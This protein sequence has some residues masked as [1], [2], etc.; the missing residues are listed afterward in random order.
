MKKQKYIKIFFVFLWF[1]TL[2]FSAIWGYD[3]PE[4]IENIKSYFKKNKTPKS[5]IV[6][7]EILEII[8][9]K[10]QNWRRGLKNKY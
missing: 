4:K 5:E 2:I 10:T 7:S 3:N 9:E 8:R 1:I 6:K